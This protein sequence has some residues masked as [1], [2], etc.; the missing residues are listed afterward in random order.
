[1][2]ASGTPFFQEFH[3]VLQ[4]DALGL[5]IKP[6]NDIPVVRGL[7][8][9]ADGMPGAAERAGVTVGSILVAVNGARRSRG[10]QGDDA[11]GE[12]REP[13]CDPGLPAPPRGHGART[14]AGPAARATLLAGAS[15]R[16]ALSWTGASS[17]RGRRAAGLPGQGPRGRRPRGRL[18]SRPRAPA[19][20]GGGRRG[21]ARTVGDLGD[22]AGSLDPRSAPVVDGD[23]GA[24]RD[25]PSDATRW[26]F[27]RGEAPEARLDWIAALTTLAVAFEEKGDDDGSSADAGATT[28]LLASAKREV[29]R[30]GYLWVKAVKGDEED[31]EETRGVGNW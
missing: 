30:Q 6:M 1:M 2:L 18:E 16:A 11:R 17:P 28:V 15:S 21:G 26:A 23:V 20:V 7:K 24:A 14:G 27:F 9:G 13:P 10:L 5:L 29:A 4:D 3:C 31:D 12:D 25:G 22:A 8:P 19:G